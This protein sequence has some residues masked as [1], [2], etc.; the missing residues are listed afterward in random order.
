MLEHGPLELLEL[1]PGLDPEL[2]DKHPARLGVCLE[3]LGL[4]ATAVQR[5]HQLRARAL[6]QRVLRD[7]RPQLADELRVEP[8]LEV[9]RDALLERLEPGLLEPRDL[10]LAEALVSQVGERRSAPERERLAE[11][12]RGS[13]RVAAAQRLAPGG[14][15]ELEA[16]DVELARLDPEHVPGRAGLERV[17]GE[18]LPEPRDG[19]PQRLRGVAPVP[20]PELFDQAVARHHL[21]R[22]EQEHAE[23]RALP[24]TADGDGA[25]AL[26]NLQGAE[27][28]ELH[29]GGYR[30]VTGL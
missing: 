27:D 3:R 8:A 15:P 12:G 13:G 1:A 26:T 29:G 30:T 11:P 6:A 9:G 2:L 22:V 25:L 4:A 21:V 5:Q 24:R 16:V 7:E 10:R 17:A 23:Q 14:H 18:G 20:V 28:A 19:H